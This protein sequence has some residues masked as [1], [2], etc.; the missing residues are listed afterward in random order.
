MGYLPPLKNLL[1]DFD[2]TLADSFAGV[3]DCAQYAF[4]KMGLPPPC[5]ESIRATIGLSLRAAFR[6]LASQSGEQLEDEFERL[7]TERGD[8]IMLAKTHLFPDTRYVLETLTRRGCRLGIV[9]TKFR[10]RVES[11]LARDRC[12]TYFQLIIAADDVRQQKPSPEGAIEAMRRMKCDPSG[13]VFVGD[14]LVDAGTARNA[15]LAMIGLTTGATTAEQLKTAGAVVVFPS[16]SGLLTLP[17]AT[18][19]T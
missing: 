9:S 11:V 3:I 10:R 7:Y 13:C 1:F 6:A 4:G 19:A 17:N 14:S 16:L 15:H 2:F 5:V 18:P 8:E 12:R